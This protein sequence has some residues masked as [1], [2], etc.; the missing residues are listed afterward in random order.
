MS[1]VNEFITVEDVEKYDLE[2]IDNKFLVGQTRARD[3]TID[4]DRD[5]Y[6]R[7][8]AIGGGADPDFRNQ[9][10]WSFYWHGELIYL[11]LDLVG[12]GGE[13]DGPGWSHWKMI[14]LNGSYGL[15]A[16]LK[17]RL[18]GILGD[19]KQALTTYQGAGIY[20]ADYS[21]YSVT[22]DIFEE[23]VL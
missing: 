3:W 13:R 2:A 20:S 23:C 17:S 8:V 1:F 12:G 14:W 5:I 11:R 21:D 9:T 16:N 22:L 7:N 6:L 18:T 15:P 4:R 10:K 19:L